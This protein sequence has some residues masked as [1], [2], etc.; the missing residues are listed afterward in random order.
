MFGPVFD[1]LNGDY[2]CDCKG[3][4]VLDV[5]GGLQG[6]S[7]VFFHRMGAKKVIIYEPIPVYLE[8]IRRNISNNGVNAEFHSAGIGNIDGTQM[9]RYEKRLCEMEVRIKA[10]ESVI[11]E[12]DADIAKFDCEG[13]EASL[14]NVHNEVLRRIQLYII[15][16]HGREVR[17][18]IIRKFNEAGYILKKEIRKDKGSTR[19]IVFLEKKP[20]GII[21]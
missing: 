9:L 14:V 15:E 6:E 11:T 21:I 2:D 4:V 19:T 16:V 17:S 1:L 7:A 18:A 20:S 10:A 3:K 12:S 8:L 5:G 13:A